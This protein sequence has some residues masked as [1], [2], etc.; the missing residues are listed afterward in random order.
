MKELKQ[1]MCFVWPFFKPYKK[2]VVPFFIFSIIYFLFSTVDALAL[3][4]LIDSMLYKQ[5]VSSIVTCSIIFFILSIMSFALCY[6]V[7]INGQRTA[8]L[9]GAECKKQLAKHIQETSLSYSSTAGS[10]SFMNQLNSDAALLMIFAANSALQLIGKIVIFLITIIIVF[11][12]D[13]V[14]GIA[15]LLEMPFVFLLY[16]AFSRKLLSISHEVAE[17]RNRYFVR[18]F[19]MLRDLRYIKLNALSDETANR[20]AEQAAKTVKVDEKE[21]KLEFVYSYIQGNM[22]VLLKIFLFFYG[23]ISVIQ[24]NISVG[25]FTIIYSYYRIITES[26]AYF[27]NFGSQI[28]ENYAY[29]ERLNKIVQTP[30]ESNGSRQLEQIHKICLENVSFGYGE[31][32]VLQNFSYQFERGKLYCIVGENGCG[33]STLTMLISGIYIDEFEG[34]ILYDGYSIKELNMK[35]L[36]HKKLGICEQEPILIVDT[37]RYNMTYENDPSADETLMQLAK[38]VS[39][40]DFLNSTEKGLDF[41]LGEGR[42]NLSG[43]QKQKIALIKA[44]F[45]NPDVL[46]L[47]EP[48]SAMDA[49]GRTRIISYLQQCKKNKIILTVTHDPELIEAA[50]EVVRM[51]A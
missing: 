49:E 36:R 43:G 27:L 12:I 46:V 22:D 37:L 23:G 41:R 20:F 2:T 33:K 45:K 5:T 18:L 35:A 31:G 19:E 42:S 16:K 50:D 7:K 8:D 32:K 9:T 10:S 3:G 17:N 6:F 47:D 11:H 29:Y 4:W 34:K 51:G 1:I 24:G 44:F 26:F 25:N 40:D 30:E 48:T 38:Q 15:A 21:T 28:Q 14:C 13:I 39:I